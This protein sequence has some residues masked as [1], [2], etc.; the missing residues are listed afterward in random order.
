MRLSRTTRNAIRIR[1]VFINEIPHER[2]P[3][4]LGSAVGHC[5]RSPAGER[6]GCQKQVLRPVGAVLIVFAG[7][8]ARR[9]RQGN[10]YLLGQLCGMFVETDDRLIRIVRFMIEREDVFYV[11]YGYFTVCSSVV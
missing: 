7:N 1:V 2:H 5:H 8:P 3:V 11:K 9:S 10:L 4:A 6:F